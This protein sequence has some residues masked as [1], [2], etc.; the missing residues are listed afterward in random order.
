MTQ[1]G[2][3]SDPDIPR[4]GW[5]FIKMRDL[6]E[7]S[8]NHKPCEMQCGAHVRFAHLM[9]HKATGLKMEVGC[10]CAGN[11]EG[12]PAAA[13]EREKT[14]VATVRRVEKRSKTLALNRRALGSIDV[15]VNGYYA[16]VDEV[17]P[18]LARLLTE[19]QRHVRE[20]GKDNDAFGFPDQLLNH[21]AFLS[22]VEDAL[23]RAR[24]RIPELLPLKAVEDLQRELR[25]AYSISNPDDD[26]LLAL[27][28]WRRTKKGY[29]FV[30]SKR[31][32]A[33]VYW[34][35]RSWWGLCQPAGAEQPT[36]RGKLDTDLGEAMRKCIKGLGR[37][38]RKAG[39][40]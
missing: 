34:M 32:V 36:T 16:L 3:W 35:G 9:H 31:D 8:A 11:M 33:Q 26:I 25:A 1:A 37:D 20:A 24:A 10:I 29:R 40:L 39:R 7:G 27:S 30:T 19:A 2:K 6:G 23:A 21:R 22:R 28:P 18:P 13:E 15:E 4:L 17:I 14:F 5:E 12:D 38:L